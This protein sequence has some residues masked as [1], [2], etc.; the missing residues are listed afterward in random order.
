MEDLQALATWLAPQLAALTPQERRALARKVAQDMRRANQT[1]IKGQTD[2]DGAA[3]VPRKIPRAPIRG[4]AGRIRRAM[5]EKLRTA[6]F[7]K[8]KGEDAAAVVD[9]AGS[10]G[11][12]AHVH[13]FGLRDRVN[14]SGG[15]EYSYPS[16]R[17]LGFAPEDI[18]RITDVVLARLAK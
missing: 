7:M 9:F 12:L 3:F 18:E 4:K 17:L 6:R 1:R 11:R 15:T 14:R 8:A 5:F 16:R 13:H 2:P 10:A